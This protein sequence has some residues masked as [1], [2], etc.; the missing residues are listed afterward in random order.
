MTTV[1]TIVP[2]PTLHRSVTEAKAQ[3][4]DLQRQ[5]ATGE[6]AE[7]YG[8]LGPERSR[9]LSF[10]GEL[11][12]IE[13]YQGTIERA[14][15]NLSVTELSIRQLRTLGSDT[16]GS[17]L[18]ARFDPTPAG[19]TSLQVEARAGFFQAAEMLNA[20]AA[21]RFVFAGRAADQKPVAP[22]QAILEGEP[23]RAGFEAVAA[24]RRAADLG[25]HGRGRLTVAAVTDTATL[26]EDAVSPFGFKLGAVSGSFTGA[27]ITGP[28]GAPQSLGVQ[29]SATLPVAGETLS[30]TLDLPDGTTT[31]FS[32]TASNGPDLAPGEFLIGADEAETATNFAAKLGETLDHLGKTQLRAASAFAAADQFFDLS[33]TKPVQRVAFTPPA[34]PE[35]ATALTA[36]DPATTVIWY[37]GEVA[38]DDPRDTALARADDNTTVRYGVR[39]NEEAFT[40]ELKALAVLALEDYPESEATARERF[41]A[42]NTRA[43]KL[44]P[45][46]G[47]TQAI[48]HVYASITYAQG[49]LE[50]AS[51]RHDASQ[52][53]LQ[54]FVADVEQVDLYEVSAQLLSLQNRLQA[55]FQTTATLSRISLVNYL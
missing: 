9:I 50:K 13:G 21:G 18:K 43:I 14:Q 32:L 46:Q 42:V 1:R 4:D 11:A 2:H 16:K 35:T 28:A 53:V 20:E 17:V 25:A 36:A 29:F 33:P 3:M 49:A 37:Q 23:G 48:D 54:D 55:S 12:Q 5:L 39:A 19:Q 31:S 30:V 38:S 47:E 27:A 52:G 24:E 34:G 41:D 45:G 15:I 40:S 7:T 10:R 8:T 22:G 44:L 51:E 26:S 6:K